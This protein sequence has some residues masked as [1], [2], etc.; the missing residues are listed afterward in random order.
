MTDQLRNRIVESYRRLD[1]DDISTEMLL[2]M[3]ADENGCDVCDVCE[4]ISKDGGRK[5]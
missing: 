4:A 3:V 2:M 1:S 5:E